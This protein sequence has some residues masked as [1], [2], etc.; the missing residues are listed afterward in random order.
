MTATDYADYTWDS[1]TLIGCLYIVIP[2]KLHLFL[3]IVYSWNT[4]PYHKCPKHSYKDILLGN[5]SQ[6][7][8]ISYLFL[9]NDSVT[10]SDSVVFWLGISDYVFVMLKIALQSK[11][12]TLN[13]MK[14]TEN[15]VAIQMHQFHTLLNVSY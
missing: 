10:N 7:I 15:N 12:L 8:A 14:L 1:S 13:Q 3:W 11:F 2:N 5:S 6:S 9:K 4:I